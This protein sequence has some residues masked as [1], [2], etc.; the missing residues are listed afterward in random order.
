[1][2]KGQSKTLIFRAR[3][4]SFSDR[5]QVYKDEQW[6][7][8]VPLK[9]L[10]GH[11]VGKWIQ[12]AERIISK[13]GDSDR[14][15]CQKAISGLRGRILEHVTAF[16]DRYIADFMKTWS[17]KITP[18]VLLKLVSQTRLIISPKYARKS[19]SKDE[20]RKDRSRESSFP[21]KKKRLSTVFSFYSV[22]FGDSF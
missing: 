6:S 8:K 9:A 4:E 16:A 22:D 11:Y 7:R 21:R 1:M 20:S 14:E 12:F 19:S 15:K 18:K 17:M 13:Y 3:P 10:S 2:P 5:N